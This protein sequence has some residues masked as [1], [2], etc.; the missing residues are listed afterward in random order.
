MDDSQ[1]PTLLAAL[2]PEVVDSCF[3]NGSFLRKR[4]GKE[5]VAHLQGEPCAAIEIVLTGT[6]SV[7]KLDEEGNAFALALFGHGALIG[8]N[9]V[10]ATKNRYPNTITSC[11]DTDV[12]IIGSETL[13]SLLRTHPAFLRRFLAAM[14]D[15]TVLVSDKL[16]DVVHRTLRD[17]LE[18]Y[19]LGEAAR[20]ESLCITLPVTK[21][22]LA[23]MLGVSRTSVSR[24][25]SRMQCEK[26]LQYVNR[27]VV[28]SP[29]LG[30]NR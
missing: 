13:F 10:F 18:A 1:R 17:K 28:L 26:L 7:E 27:R 23:N 25:L 20:Q 14:S 24:E 19:L 3:T 29:K 5:E 16:A 6:L 21:T 12:I 4:Y 30:K 9:L 11:T 8:G 2:P 15:N 22:R